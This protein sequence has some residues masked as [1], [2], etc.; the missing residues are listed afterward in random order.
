[1]PCHMWDRAFDDRH[2]E[3]PTAIEKLAVANQP[4]AALSEAFGAG[5]AEGGLDIRLKQDPSI[6]VVEGFAQL[7][8]EGSAEV[9]GGQAEAAYMR[10]KP[11]LEPQGEGAAVSGRYRP[12]RLH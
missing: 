6:V 4:V 12:G 9:F 11:G 3:S 2:V 8:G 5:V 7:L 1:V 10:R